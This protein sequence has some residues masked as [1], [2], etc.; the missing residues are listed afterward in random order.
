MSAFVSHDGEDNQGIRAEVHVNTIK[1]T[2]KS[3]DDSNPKSAKVNFTVEWLKFPVGGWIGKTE[4]AFAL[5]QE[6][7]ADG[8]EVE[9]R[10]ESQRKGGI[11]RTIPIEELRGTAEAA[12]KNTVSLVVAVNSSDGWV[13]TS[14]ALTHPSE[15]PDNGKARPA[16][17]VEQTRPQAPSAPSLNASSIL[18]TLTK[19]ASSREV[20][21]GVI[22]AIKAQALLAGATPADIIAA[23][24]FDQPVP[25]QIQSGFSS[26]A[27]VFKEYNSDGRVNLGNYTV[28]AGVS[29]EHFTTTTLREQNPDTL[30]VPATVEFYSQLV[31]AITDVIQI[32]SYGK[33]FR[34]DRTATSHGRIRGVVFDTIKEEHPFPLT[35]TG[36]PASH[37]DVNVWVQNVGK[38]ARARFLFAVN[39]A[40]NMPGVNAILATLPDAPNGTAP[41]SAPATQVATPPAPASAPQVEAPQETYEAPADEYPTDEEYP[42]EDTYSEPQYVPEPEP[43][44]VAPTATSKTAT[45][46]EDEDLLTFP[47]Q[48]LP[49][50]AINAGNAPSEEMKDQ[51]KS[52][53]QE[54]VGL[55]DKTDLVKVGKLLGATFGKSY[56]KVQNIP[57]DL[58]GDFLDF[59]VMAGAD[60]FKKVLATF[61]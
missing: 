2:I 19:L 13:S 47:S 36:E 48:E 56:N 21:E 54:E 60:N 44:A 25:Q 4:P 3:I 41:A 7:Q 9:A 50:G 31:L 29:A 57:E 10:I 14:E 40:Y 42:E 30:V 37:E 27:P 18:G 43:V 58:L 49:P 12:Q 1:G 23:T 28:T 45:L 35:R 20:S 38:R 11:D 59:Y 15:D 61:A 22:D 6:A 26:E 34:T 24:T 52:F 8:R 53:V 33:G 46:P 32:T 39:I 5:L 51:F 55:T 16:G 17:P